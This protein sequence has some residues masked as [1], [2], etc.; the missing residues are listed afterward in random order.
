M[1]GPDSVELGSSA[2]AVVQT[3][4][5]NVHYEKLKAGA[6]FEILEG[7]HVVGKGVVIRELSAQVVAYF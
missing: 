7:P 2:T 4:F 3:I 5:D 6:Q 1:R